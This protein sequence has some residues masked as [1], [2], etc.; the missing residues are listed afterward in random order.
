[1]LDHLGVVIAGQ[2]RLAPAARRHRQIAD[3]IAH[4]DIGRG[5]QLRVLVQEVIDLPTLVGDP[6]VETLLPD[7]VVEDHEVGTQDLVQAAQHLERVELVL[8]AL[9]VHVLGLGRQIGAGRVDD[10]AARLEQRRERRLGEPLDPQAGNLPAQ[11][12]GDGDVPPGMAQPDGGADQQGARRLT[13]TPSRRARRT[14]AHELADQPVH[15]NRVPRRRDVTRAGELHVAGAG[16][17]GQ[18]EPARERLAVVQVALDDQHRAADLP[19][20][21][22]NRFFRVHDPHIVQDLRLHPAVEPV[23]DGV[24]E[25]LGRVRLGEHLAEEEL[26]EGGE[27]LR[28]EVA[29]VLEPAFVALQHLIEDVHRRHPERMPGSKQRDAWRDCDDSEDCDPT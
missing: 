10:L 20:D 21:R 26:Q 17:L 22:L 29:V 12:A 5:L 4:P 24:L 7:E 25:L 1:M 23:G 19:A 18:R 6:E 28:H 15:P 8:A 9:G 14:I 13:G 3:E 16:Q 11:L 2:E 27:I